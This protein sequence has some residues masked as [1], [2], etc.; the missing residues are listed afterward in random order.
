MIVAPVEDQTGCSD[1]N[2]DYVECCSEFS[3]TPDTSVQ[4]TPEPSPPKKRRVEESSA[5]PKGK[6]LPLM[7]TKPKKA[8]LPK[9]SLYFREMARTKKTARKKTSGPGKAPHK[10]FATKNPQKK[11]TPAQARKN[12]AKANSAVQK[13][14]GNPQTGGIKK[15]IRWKPGTV[16]L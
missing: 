9:D 2:S 13:N 7:A 8:M 6:D 15:P 16:A 1:H 3:S 4:S 11:L 12:A 14:L 10:G 5:K